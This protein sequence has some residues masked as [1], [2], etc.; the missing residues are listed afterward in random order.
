M[1]YPFIFITPI[2]QWRYK[3]H[4]GKYYTARQDWLAGSM[5]VL[6]PGEAV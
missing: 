3:L 2:E 5:D 6:Q 1:L 4:M